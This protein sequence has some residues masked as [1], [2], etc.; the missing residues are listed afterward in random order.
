MSVTFYAAT[1]EKHCTEP[2]AAG[3]DEQN[4]LNVANGNALAIL[5]A[6]FP[7]IAKAD[8]ATIGYMDA[9]LFEAALML[10]IES[11]PAN[12]HA[13]LWRLIGFVAGSEATHIA[14]S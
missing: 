5:D 2:V 7:G 1:I 8:G 9:R 3:F 4:C 12:Y 14:W 11:V 13:R 6:M 10:S